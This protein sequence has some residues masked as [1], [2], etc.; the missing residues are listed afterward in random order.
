MK[1]LTKKQ[2]Q[3][4]ATNPL[5]GV[6]ALVI[7][8]STA[9]K[10]AV[11]LARKNSEAVSFI[12]TPRLYQY[13]ETGQLL[14]ETENDDPCGFLVF[15]YTFPVL[16]IY[17]ACI[18]YDA[19]RIQHGINLLR[20]LIAYAGRYGF[21]AIS[22]YCADDLEA[23]QFWQAAGFQFVGQRQGGQRRGRMHNR[24]IMYLSSPLQLEL[25][26]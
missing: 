15:G 4:E 23:N 2:S 1:D 17:Q 3:A 18:Q 16:K 19:R 13:A 5:F 6:D 8:H 10:Y 9:V 11:D 12:P 20:R 24:W 26:V 14:I 25:A 22:L 21:T 7:P